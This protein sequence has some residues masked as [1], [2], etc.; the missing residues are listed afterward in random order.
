MGRTDVSSADL[1]SSDEPG[2]GRRATRGD[3]SR[4]SLP[5]CSGL[6]PRQRAALLLV[7]V[8]GFSNAEVSEVLGVTPSAVNSLLSRAREGARMSGRA[9]HAPTPNDERVQVLLWIAMSMPGKLAMILGCS[10]NSSPRMFVSRCR[11]CW[12]GSKDE[13]QL[14]ISSSKRVF[15]VRSSGGH[16]ALAY[17]VRTANRA[18]LATIYQPDAEAGLLTVS[19]LQ[20][21]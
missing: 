2:A 11:R 21:A 8:L 3:Q 4:A 9:R 16:S 5:H 17:L 15:A 7:D 18:K 19:G 20:G 13:N 1:D 12:H 6:K 10:S 14:P